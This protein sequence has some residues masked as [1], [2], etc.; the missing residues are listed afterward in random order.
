MRITDFF[1]S[2]RFFAALTVSGLLCAFGVSGADYYWVGGSADGSGRYLWTNPANWASSQGGSGG[3]GVPGNGDNAYSIESDAYT[4]YITSSVTVNGFYPGNDQSIEISGGAAL[5][6]SEFREQQYNSDTISFSGSG[7]LV[8][9]KFISPVNMS[10]TDED[11]VDIQINS[12]FTME[13]TD[14]FGL[15]RRNQDDYPLRFT[16]SGTLGIPA[17]GEYLDEIGD[18][19]NSYISINSSLNLVPLGDPTY[20]KVYNVDIWSPP[21]SDGEHC[22]FYLTRASDDPYSAIIYY[23]YEVTSYTGEDYNIKIVNDESGEEYYLSS[24]DSDKFRVLNKYGANYY[25]ENEFRVYFDDTSKMNPGDGYT[26]KIYSPDGR[27]L[28]ETISYTYKAPTG[29]YRWN[30]AVSNGSW[31]DNKN[32][33]TEVDD[34][35]GSLKWELD[36]D[37]PYTDSIVYFTGEA[38]VTCNFNIYGGLTISTLYTNTAGTEPVNLLLNFPLNVT[39]DGGLARGNS[40]LFLGIDNYPTGGTDQTGGNLIISGPSKLTVGD[41]DQNE[42]AANSLKLINGAQMQVNGNF[43]ADSMVNINSD[44]GTII[45]GDGTGTFS[46][47]YVNYNGTGGYFSVYI[48]RDT[49]GSTYVNYSD[50]IPYHTVDVTDSTAVKTDYELKRTQSIKKISRLFYKVKEYRGDAS[51]TVGSDSVS[52]LLAEGYVDIDADTEKTVQLLQPSS[53]SGDQKITVEYYYCGYLVGS[54]SYRNFIEWSGALS[55]DASLPANWVDVTDIAQLEGARIIVPSVVSGRYPDFGK[56]DFSIGSLVLEGGSST[57]S[58]GSSKL[59]VASDF[60]IKTGASF[61]AAGGTV[62]FTGGTAKYLDEDGGTASSTS[63]Y[64]N[65]VQ[66]N[67]GAALSSANSVTVKGNWSDSGSFSQTAGSIIFSSTG[68][69]ISST[70]GETFKNLVIDGAITSDKAVTA[71][72]LLISGS[73]SGLTVSSGDLHVTGN[74]SLQN[75]LVSVTDGKAIFDDSLELEGDVS[76]TAGT[77]VFQSDISEKPSASASLTVTGDAEIFKA[78]SPSTAIS[79]SGLTKADISGKLTVGNGQVFSIQSPVNVTGGTDFTRNSHVTVASS[80]SFTGS[81]NIFTHEGTVLSVAGDFTA[82]KNLHHDSTVTAP[83]S[84]IETSGNFSVAGMLNLARQTGASEFNVT[85]G[86]AVVRQLLSTAGDYSNADSEYAVTVSGGELKVE[87]ANPSLINLSDSFKVNVTGGSFT[88]S[89]SSNSE[90]GSLTVSGGVF[91]NKSGSE[92]KI[93][94]LNVADGIELKHSGSGAL[95]VTDLVPAGSLS[96]VNSGSGNIEVENDFTVAGDTSFTGAVTFDEKFKA[97]ASGGRTISL[98]GPVTVKNDLILEGTAGNLLTV[99]GNAAGKFILSSSQKNGSYLRVLCRAENGPKISNGIIDGGNTY[100]ATFSEVFSA[101]SPVKRA[102]AGWNIMRSGEIA[103][104]WIGGTETSTGSGIFSWDEG[105]NWDTGSVP[106]ADSKVLVGYNTLLSVTGWP[107]LSSDVEIG[108]IQLSDAK[109]DTNDTESILYLNSHGLK[110]TESWKNLTTVV[111]QGNEN[112]SFPADSSKISED[113]KWIFEGGSILNIENGTGYN[114][115]EINEDTATDFSE[116]YAIS[117]ADLTVAADK[118]LSVNKNGIKV[119]GDFKNYGTVEYKSTPRITSNGTTVINDDS[120]TDNG[121]VVYS[122]PAGGI[123]DSVDFANLVISDGTWKTPSTAQTVKTEL[124]VEAGKTLSVA[125]SSTF[126]VKAVDS[127]GTVS[128]SSG[129]FLLAGSRADNSVAE[130]KVSGG[131]FTNGGSGTVTITDCEVSGGAVTNSAAGSIAVTNA[132]VTGGTVTNSGSGVLNAD[133]LKISGG[134]V[135]RAGSGSILV[136]AAEVSG[137]T[138]KNAAENGASLNF[139]VA[140]LEVTGSEQTFS[141]NSASGKL[142]IDSLSVPVTAED[143]VKIN[144][145]EFVEYRDFTASGLGGKTLFVNGAVLLTG[146]LVLSGTDED[147][148]LSITGS[149]LSYIQLPSS[150]AGGEFLS[151][152]IVT[153]GKDTSDDTDP[154]YTAANSIPSDP[155]G[156]VPHGWVID[157]TYT[158]NGSQSVYWNNRRNWTP[159]FIPFKN[160][161]IVIPPAANQPELTSAVTHSDFEVQTGAEL[162]LKGFGLSVK[163]DWSNSG[164]VFAD[165]TETILFASDQ[166]DSGVWSYFRNNSGAGGTVKNIEKLS[167]NKILIEGDGK[168]GGMTASELKFQNSSLTPVS[169]TSTGSSTFAVPSIIVETDTT[170]KLNAFPLGLGK[171][172]E[173]GNVT[174]TKSLTIRGDMRGT[175]ERAS[176]RCKVKLDGDFEISNIKGRA[177]ICDDVEARN[178]VLDAKEITLA[179]STMAAGSAPGITLKAGNITLGSGTVSGEGKN[180]KVSAS[181]RALIYAQLG[182]DTA[183]L[184]DVTSSEAA[185]TNIFNGDIFASSLTVEG[186]TQFGK[187]SDQKVKT[188]KTGVVNQLYKDKVSIGSPLTMAAGNGSVE[189][190]SAV[191][192]VSEGS[193]SLTVETGIET[194]CE[195]VFEG[196][197]GSSKALSSLEVS[198]NT[199]TMKGIG[200]AGKNGVTG[201]VIVTAKKN[202]SGGTGTENSDIILNS[203]NYLTG[204]K[205]TFTGNVHLKP[206]NDGKW[207]AGTDGIETGNLYAEH[208]DKAIELGSDLK[209]AA[210][211]FTSGD[212][213]LRNVMITTTGS[214]SAW[215]SKFN[216]DDPQFAG[217][218]TRFDFAGAEKTVGSTFASFSVLDNAKFV[219][220]GKFYINGLDLGYAGSSLTITLTDNKDSKVTFNS[221]SRADRTSGTMWG[222]DSKYAVVFNSKIQNCTVTKGFIAAASELQNVTNGGGN[223]EATEFDTNGKAVSNKTSG[224]QF[225]YPKIIRAYS[226]YDDVIFVEFNMPLENSN[227][228]I[229]T[230]VAMSSA[231]ASGGVWINGGTVSASLGVFKDADC[232]TPL[233]DGD[234]KPITELYI[235]SASKWNT[236]ATGSTSYLDTTGADASESTD[237]D[238]VHRDVTTDLSWLTGLF[239]AEYGHTHCADYGAGVNPAYTATEDHC[240]PVLVEVYTGQEKHTPGNKTVQKE[241]DAHNFIEFHYSEAVDIGDLKADGGDVNVQVQKTFNAS[242]HGGAIPNKASGGFTVTG[243]GSFSAGGVSAGINKT[244]SVEYDASQVHALYRKFSTTSSDSDIKNQTH[245][246]RLSIGGFV[247]GEIS[248]GGTYHN[249]KGYLDKVATPSGVFTRAGNLNIK[250]RAGDGTARDSL[251]TTPLYNVYD[252]QGTAS[253]HALKPL[254]VNFTSQ[255][256]YTTQVVSTPLTVYGNW[257]TE[258]PRFAPFSKSED[259]FTSWARGEPVKS[260]EVVGSVTT[261]SSSFLETIEFHLFDNKSYK[262]NWWKSKIGWMKTGV[263]DSTFTGLPETIGGSRDFTDGSGVTAQNQTTGGIRRSSLEGANKAFTYSYT[264]DGTSSYRSA[265]TAKLISQNV[266]SNVFRGTGDPITA[267]D[268]LY[269]S[270]PLNVNDLGI[271]TARTVFEVKFS[272]SSCYMT[273]LAGNRIDEDLTMSSIDLIPPAFSMNIAPIGTNKIYA[274]FTKRLAYNGT[275]LDRLSPSKFREFKNKLCESF[276]VVKTGTST[277]TEYTIKDVSFKKCSMDYTSLLFT[278]S[279]TVT[280]S[281]VETLSIRAKGIAGDMVENNSGIVVKNTYISDEAGNYLEEGKAHVI[282]DFAVNAVNVLYA[283]ADLKDT[284]WDEKGIYGTG[285]TSASSQ[286]YAVHQFDANAGNYGK[287]RTGGDITVQVR[288]KNDNDETLQ[289]VVDKKSNLKGSWISNS[290]NKLTKSS[291]RIWLNSPLTSL[292]TGYNTNVLNLPEL[293]DVEGSPLLKNFTLKDEVFKFKGGDEYQFLFKIRNSTND[294]DITI[295]H[296]NDPTTPE[297]PLF[298]LWMPDARIAMGD[299]SFLD[300]WSFTLSDVTKQRGGVTILNNVIDVS[301]KEQTVIEVDMK[302]SGNL[303]VYVMTLDGNIV[304]RLSK[305]H[306]EAGTHYFKWDGTNNSGKAVARGLYFIRV[307]G[308]NIDETRKVMCVKN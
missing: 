251:G 3:A 197:I 11:Y 121:T 149:P 190:K 48:D 74:T 189:F 301:V 26:I 67:D 244:T 172:G 97:L 208:K 294:A 147:N 296:D 158:W 202:K 60:E 228:E 308:Q 122:N 132:S 80:G 91:E 117:C 218:D 246:L 154:E 45:S 188:S 153:V 231:L 285:V 220:G 44:A 18:S 187:A 32:W 232:V 261:D 300:L 181:A 1:S 38:P 143:S 43:W 40:T 105:L 306:V 106:E 96:V 30:N 88:P 191:D 236:D 302:S 114:V 151:V 186:T 89:V 222:E 66:I 75:S 216:N 33:Y 174:G 99:T 223:T 131:D 77:A 64:F 238:G 135:T 65:N 255:D 163:G 293:S 148:L 111:S 176:V 288:F 130:L 62:I 297:I 276:V 71:E 21:D 175:D 59:T 171:T 226:V 278:L 2:C 4:I 259:T 257:D 213:K 209:A 250:D 61:K 83:L 273:D 241:Y 286:D 22:N 307:S 101:S 272:P 138:L 305:G 86:T 42:Y 234:S 94:A 17:S 39:G 129:E 125:G 56:A 200:T 140:S 14:Q 119:T 295:D 229:N 41:L 205:Q 28:L 157:T 160:S 136:T 267:N 70:A 133:S 264:L 104:N 265:D 85:G 98:L 124:K 217:A 55:T 51:Y 155:E 233:S 225:G 243:Y 271:L 207:A 224:F 185:C 63:S 206:L 167:F 118:T 53:T 258:K 142:F 27:F 256:G 58:A 108:E 247:D 170:L 199:V 252:G 287:L 128:V 242:E 82:K 214:F 266:K 102:P 36:F 139:T 107:T 289:M 204:G 182:K 274:I 10:S 275:R 103:W 123:I 69:S 31:A 179:N 240:A 146:N 284:G 137:G 270:V 93:A 156:E 100:T 268:G 183:P 9:A 237:R 81:E 52:A 141:G 248:A 7:K 68:K 134:N 166:T 290:L 281:S 54:A 249:W 193:G 8:C 16:G 254:K 291:W 84:V 127:E 49:S 177:D 169:L 34:G 5:S 24:G 235:R 303:N 201:T 173:I 19:D 230:A 23:P 20:Y 15:Y 109:T 79:V 221:L 57:V 13:I 162:T 159:A 161:N 277:E 112:V 180:L 203:E 12:G 210:L 280:L 292:S 145:D 260:Y 113:G 110:V 245:R 283:F 92:L 46:H 35:S 227:N 299:F 253:R 304:K 168:F 95:V 184:G 198:S 282:S 196:L 6:C 126:T 195:V 194:G 269:L 164:T 212:F 262:T 263:E 298:A 76:V 165:G 215:G 90:I 144:S 37:W 72:T 152:G 150:Q 211:Y 120:V 87:S 47:G 50:S 29:R 219:T 239:V 115:V 116:N 25:T 78:S 178:I 279:D 192:A 73:S